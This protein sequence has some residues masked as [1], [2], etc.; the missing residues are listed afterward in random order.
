MIFFI[1][2]FYI[3]PVTLYNPEPVFFSTKLV[4]FDLVSLESQFL[5]RESKFK[6]K[7]L[8]HGIR[9]LNEYLLKLHT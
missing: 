1:D 4:N 8:G 6:N 5:I 7:I 9:F 3:I 2:F